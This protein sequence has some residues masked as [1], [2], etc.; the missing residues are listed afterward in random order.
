MK[1]TISRVIS[2]LDEDD[3][4]SDSSADGATQQSIKA[5]TDGL[6]A[7]ETLAAVTA[8]GATTT[9]ACIFND[10]TISSGQKLIVGDSYYSWDGDSVNGYLGDDTP[11]W[12]WD[13]N[14]IYIED[15]RGLYLQEAITFTGATTENQ[16][17][18]PD[19]LPDAL[20]VKW[21]DGTF[22]TFVTSDGSETITFGTTFAG[23]TGSTI[24]TLTLANGS[25]TD[26]GGTISFGNENLSTTGTLGAGA[27][28][29]TT[30]VFSA[31]GATV[32]I[33]RDEDTMSSDDAN[34]LA[35]QQSIKAYVDTLEDAIS[36]PINIFPGMQA[37]DTVGQGTWLH[38]SSVPDGYLWSYLYNTAAADGDNIT[39]NFR[40]PAGTYTLT[41]VG[42]GSTDS[43]IIDIYIDASEEGSKDCYL[44]SRAGL[45]HEITSI[46]LS[47]GAHTVKLTV[48]GKN[49]SS[50]GYQ[51]RH[52]AIILT[53]TA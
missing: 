7:A 10:V 19:N 32:D 21:G 40:C 45:R 30:L 52:A 27:T 53:R 5:Y 20:S 51:A 15:G 28:T 38:G 29:V 44:A 6:I 13:V 31:G 14:G 16:I 43:G 49:A 9:T 34:A 17:Q 42:T 50:S 35:T 2:L 46:S 23:V 12:N 41:Y 33:V 3:F 39:W 24:G 25:I 18:L 37:P 47:A 26:S 4:A 8:R 36:I 1:G 48:D 11:I 22:L